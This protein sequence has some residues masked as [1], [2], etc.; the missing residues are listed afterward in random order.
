MWGIVKF[1]MI[2]LSFVT[3]FY[4]AAFWFEDVEQQR[5]FEIFLDLM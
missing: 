2:G 3:F 4:S 1:F 5:L